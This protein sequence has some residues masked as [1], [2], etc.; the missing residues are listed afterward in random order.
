MKNVGGASRVHK[1]EFAVK[2]GCSIPLSIPESMNGSLTS[3]SS[4]L[5]IAFSPLFLVFLGAMAPTKKTLPALQAR[6]A[7]KI[8]RIWVKCLKNPEHKCVFKAGRTIP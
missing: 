8:H 5:G 7:A 3:M 2:T 4:V 1:R 6:K